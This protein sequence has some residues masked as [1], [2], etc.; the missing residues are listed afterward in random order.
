MGVERS[1]QIVH[2]PLAYAGRKILFGVG[3]HRIK[4][5]NSDYCGSSKL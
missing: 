2:Y 1:A 5:G 3:T 4:D